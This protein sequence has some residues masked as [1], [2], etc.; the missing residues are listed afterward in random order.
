[1][2]V[3]SFKLKGYSFWEVAWF[4]FT[5]ISMVF[6]VAKIKVVVENALK[7]CKRYEFDI[8]PKGLTE[9]NLRCAEY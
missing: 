1:M 5:T 8:I 9:P 7:G 4:L 6:T 3:F 2:G